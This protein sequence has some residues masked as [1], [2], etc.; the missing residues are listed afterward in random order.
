MK[1]IITAAITINDYTIHLPLS[2]SSPSSPSPP[3]PPVS[4][5]AGHMNDIELTTA[6]LTA[7]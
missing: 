3:S 2:P 6:S 5:S 4:F 1:N 7:G